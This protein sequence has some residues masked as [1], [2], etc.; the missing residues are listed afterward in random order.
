M[1]EGSSHSAASIEANRGWKDD[2]ERKRRD[3]VALTSALASL[4]KGTRPPPGGQ[5]AT[6]D[7]EGE[8]VLEGVGPSAALLDV[9]REERDLLQVGEGGQGGEVLERVEPQAEGGE[10]AVAEVQRRHR[11]VVQLQ[12]QQLE[13]GARLQEGGGD[14]RD[15]VVAQV[16]LLQHRHVAH[17][18]EGEVGQL[19]PPQA[20]HGQLRVVDDTVEISCSTVPIVALWPCTSSS[21]MSGS[22]FCRSSASRKVGD[23]CM[24]SPSSLMTR[25]ETSPDAGKGRLPRTSLAGVLTLL[26]SSQV[27]LLTNSITPD[28]AS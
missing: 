11:D 18:G 22:L 28:S 14:L 23:I 25:S 15:P 24:S 21:A 8:K 5:E 27:T 17:G 3:I 6:G 26:I 4:V 10:A 19:A 16:Q 9:Q 12:V 7:G 2:D 20:E 1:K 13:E